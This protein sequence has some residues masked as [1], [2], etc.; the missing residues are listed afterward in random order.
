[1][2]V[3]ERD[4]KE[5]NETGK[6]ERLCVGRTEFLGRLVGKDITGRWGWHLK[7]SPEGREGPSCG[8]VWR[9]FQAPWRAGAKIHGEM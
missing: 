2:S 6:K 8:H 5:K 1:M 7:L 9:T 3:L 4:V